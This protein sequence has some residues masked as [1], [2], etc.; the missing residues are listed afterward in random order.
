MN[1]LKNKVKNKYPNILLDNARIHH[2]RILKESVTD[3]RFI[4]NIPYTPEYNP[5]EQVFSKLKYLLRISNLTNENTLE[6]IKLSLNKITTSEL[7]GYFRNSFK[8]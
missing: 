7:E 8:F 6:N 1:E 2:A 3:I 5:K 4:Y